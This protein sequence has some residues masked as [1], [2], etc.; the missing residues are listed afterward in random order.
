VEKAHPV[1]GAGDSSADTRGFGLLRFDFSYSDFCPPVAADAPGAIQSP[2]MNASN[3]EITF[4][5]AVPL[6]NEQDGLEQ[7][8]ARLTAAAA[9]LGES[10]E[11]VYV[12]DGSTD[13]TAAVLERMRAA[14]EHIKVVELSRNFGHQLAVTAGYDHAEGRAVISLDGDCQHPPEK[15]PEL[16]AL[17]RE[18][19]EVVYTVRGDTEGISPLRRNLGRAVYRVISLVSGMDLADQADF[20]LLD[21]QVV[22]ALRAHREQGRFVRAMVR[23]LGFK[24][25]S[26]PYVAQQ[27]TAGQSNYSMRQLARMAAAGVFNFSLAPVRTVAA[28]GAVLLGATAVVA[29]FGGL[30]G[31]IGIGSGPGLGTLVVGA[32]GLNL[33]AL[34]VVGEYV[35]RTFE[36]VKGRPL[37]VVRRKVGFEP[38]A[39]PVVEQQA[40][41]PQAE[42]SPARRYSIFT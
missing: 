8:H 23:Y 13:E 31:L 6:F 37:Y 2:S 22:L 41:K 4:S 1:K 15:I 38:P 14:D 21:R 3:P 17:W 10:Y 19:C 11:I 27:R 30:L 34:G 32:T 9:E 28:V 36:Q 7:F 24:Q 42:A 5:F 40:S 35:G 29:V 12:N 39:E 20:R 26:V 16:V 18:G 33:L 25:A